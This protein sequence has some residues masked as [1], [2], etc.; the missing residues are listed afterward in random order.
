MRRIGLWVPLLALGAC[1]GPA[2]PGGPA[3]QP[4][5]PG[6]DGGPGAGGEDGE[7]GEDGGSHTLVFE[8]IGVATTDDEKRAVRASARAWVDGTEVPLQYHTLVRSGEIVGTGTFGLL[9]GQ[10]GAPLTGRDG[11]LMISKDADFT[12]LHPVGSEVYAVTHLESQ[13]GGMYLTRL[14][15]D[16]AT[17]ALVAV[18]TGPVDFSAWHGLWTPCAGSVSP[19]GT[20]LGGEEYPPEARLWDEADT[21]AQ[22]GVGDR[23][24]LAYLGLDAWSDANSDG[25]PDLPLSVADAAYNPYWY[26]YPNEIL[27]ELG[28]AT[29]VKH[30]SMGRVS[31]ELAKVMPDQRTVY[32]TD[33]GTN[34][35]LYLYVADAPGDLSAG[36]LYAMKWYQISDAGAGAADL[37]WISL[38]HAT[39]AEIAAYLQADLRFLD[40]FEVALPEA[41][42]ESCPDDFVGINTGDRGRE[43]LRLVPGM[44]QAASRLETRRY[45]AWLGATTELRKEEGL[46]HDPLTNTLYLAISEVEYGMEDLERTGLPDERHD[47][48][49]PNDI[50]LAYNKCGAVYALD[51]AGHATIGSD[52]VAENMY[53][54]VEGVPYPGASPFPGNACSVSHLANPDNLTFVEG[55][56]TLIIGED[57]TVGHQNDVLWAYDQQTGRLDRIFSTPYGAE[58]TSPYWY[59]DL[60]GFGYLTAVVQHPFGETDQLQPHDP[61]DE[62]AYVGYLG[63]FPSMSQ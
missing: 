2:G 62:A 53:A 38:G 11:S 39:D 43:C 61:L 18:D 30:Y 17:G 24:M 16:G 13:P 36:T 7:D 52:Y 57:A 20:H 3:G 63:P 22:L 1:E 15:Q 47:A 54:Y 29:P 19:W 56:G 40:L 35:G 45:A 31:I 34:V 33:D 58:T 59:P 6:Q 23:N 10:D 48:L 50:R 37:G 60:G 4:G 12:S 44:E 28:G 51:L 49:G 21:V 14:T 5:A 27:V 26:G 9:T 32:I 42:E 41:G 25:A 55:Y 46:A 8:D